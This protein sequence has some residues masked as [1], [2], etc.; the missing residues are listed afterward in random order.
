MQIRC[1]SVDPTMLIERKSTSLSK[2][3]FDPDYMDSLGFV[4]IERRL[5]QRLFQNFDT[6]FVEELCRTSISHILRPIDIIRGN[7][8]KPSSVIRGDFSSSRNTDLNRC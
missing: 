4:K 3:L 6:I 2:V 5:H 1:T 7:L 8:L